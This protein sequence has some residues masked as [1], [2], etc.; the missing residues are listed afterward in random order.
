MY[1]L[2]ALHHLWMRDIIYDSRIFGIFTVCIR[3]YFYR[4]LTAPL[5]GLSSSSWHVSQ[6]ITAT[7]WLYRRIPNA[8]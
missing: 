2:V 3:A 4:P 8:R 5:L 7:F 6:L 1:Y